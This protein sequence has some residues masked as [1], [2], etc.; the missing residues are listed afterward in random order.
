M[1]SISEIMKAHS[2]LAVPAATQ[3]PAATP[4]SVATQ[5]SAGDPGFR[6]DPGLCSDPP[7]GD[8][9]FGRGDAGPGR[10]DGGPGR[11]DVWSEFPGARGPPG[12]ARAPRGMEGGPDPRGPRSGLLALQAACPRQLHKKTFKERT[13][14][15]SSLPFL[16]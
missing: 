16:A 11:G 8:P 3:G 10:G 4:G 7:R 5:G 6:G 1:C 9:G 14:S 12:S 2:E 13:S 15:K